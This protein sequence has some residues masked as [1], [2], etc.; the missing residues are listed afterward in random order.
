M[1]VQRKSMHFYTKQEV[2]LSPTTCAML[3]R[4]ASFYNV[5]RWR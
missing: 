3:L 5:S 1:L 4:A 2:Q